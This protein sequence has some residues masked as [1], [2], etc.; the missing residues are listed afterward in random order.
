MVGKTVSTSLA[1]LFIL[2][3]CST[4]S[5]N[6]VFDS[7]NQLTIEQGSKNLQWIKTPQESASVDESVR[8]LLSGR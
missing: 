2:S 7:V 3:G 1:A 6:E 5:Q 8:V 4:I